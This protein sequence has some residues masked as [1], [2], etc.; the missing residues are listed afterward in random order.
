MLSELLPPIICQ[1]RQTVAAKLTKFIGQI[2]LLI[3]SFQP[4][5]LHAY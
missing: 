4:E 3:D 5:S 1:D 2:P